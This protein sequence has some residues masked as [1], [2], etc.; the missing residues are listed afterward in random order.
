MGIGCKMEREIINYWIDR[1]ETEKRSGMDGSLAGE[2]VGEALHELHLRV[3]AAHVVG[4]LLQE[5]AVQIGRA[6][7]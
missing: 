4:R 7:V 3:Q 2:K 5:A 1:P 6:H